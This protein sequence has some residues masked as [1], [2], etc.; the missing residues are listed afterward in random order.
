MRALIPL[1]IASLVASSLSLTGSPGLA[2]GQDTPLSTGIRQEIGAQHSARIAS[3]VAK[4]S[5]NTSS[6]A[7]AAT[8][9]APVASASTAGHQLVQPTSQAAAALSS[10]ADRPSGSASSSPTAG[11][12]EPTPHTVSDTSTSNS[13]KT[14][15]PAPK[16]LKGGV[17]HTVSPFKG[18]GTTET[19]KQGTSV[20]LTFS[21]NLNSEISQV[22]DRV[23]ARVSTDLKDGGKVVLPGQWYVVGKISRLE[24]RKRM[25]RDGFAEIKFEKLVSPDCK[26]E[27]PI[28]ATI[29]TKDSTVKTVVT[30][31][32]KGSKHMGIGAFAGS[33]LS[34]Q[35]GGIGT[36]ISTYG[37]S[38]GVGAAAGATAGLAAF[39]SKKG[40]ILCTLPGDEMS[41][42]LPVP[43]Q[44]P[45]FNQ[46][47]LKIKREIPKLDNVNISVLEKRFSAHPYG[48]KGARLLSVK[49]RI[50]NRSNKTYGFENIAVLSDH[51][52]QY[53][54]YVASMIDKQ[55]FQKVAPGAAKEADITYDVASP[56]LKYWLVLWDQARSNILSQVPIN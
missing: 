39:L 30:Q 18:D 3:S 13:A 33:L 41:V 19:I 5:T 27:A 47:V 14:T 44:I 32:A 40:D 16:I 38:V 31:V 45:A 2:N 29:S 26:F 21:A 15:A 48:D 24:G 6:P 42:R 56:K 46:E 4:A 1:T 35:I 28:D 17:S 10:G 34:L 50:E 49:I 52:D 20:N 23:I 25:G 7:A 55:R 53:T 22:G 36:A 8:S 43:V 37:I 12:A 51:G 11:T 9:S 54:P